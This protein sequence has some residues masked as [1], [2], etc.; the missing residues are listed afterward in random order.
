M[1]QQ[2]RETVLNLL[3]NKIHPDYGESQPRRQG[4]PQQAVDNAT[5]E[6]LRAFLDIHE[7]LSQFV[8]CDHIRT[9]YIGVRASTGG[10]GLSYH[11]STIVY[12]ARDSE[13][14]AV[15][16]PTKPRYSGV[17]DVYFSGHARVPIRG[18]N[19]VPS[20]LG[21]R[22]GLPVFRAISD[23]TPQFVRQTIAAFRNAAHYR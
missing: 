14:Q 6:S 11:R 5:P 21:R 12:G 16:L 15:L 2:D 1:I 4:L 7:A 18:A 17:L 9:R 23:P 20:R 19:E 8:E 10:Y 22:V 3:R 13:I